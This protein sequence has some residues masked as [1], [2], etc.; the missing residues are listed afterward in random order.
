M[1]AASRRKAEFVPARVYRVLGHPIL[2]TSIFLITWMGPVVY[3]GLWQNI[4]QRAGALTTALLMLALPVLLWKSGA[5]RRRSV[6]MLIVKEDNNRVQQV[7][8][9]TLAAGRMREADIQLCY[10]TET[11]DLHTAAGEA[12]LPDELRE[13]IFTLPAS[14]VDDLLVWGFR[15]GPD[16]TTTAL[17]GKVHVYQGKTETPIDLSPDGGRAVIPLAEGECQVKI[18]LIGESE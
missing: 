7:S 17:N 2:L 9:A 16:D 5:F 1:L 15:L 18:N 12:P 6:A 10:P 8:F 4:F 14:P 13:V 11:R 3:I